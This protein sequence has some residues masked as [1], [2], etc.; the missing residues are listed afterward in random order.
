MTSL[1]HSLLITL[2]SLTILHIFLQ[3]LPP[4][5]HQAQ[6]S[7][8]NE[9]NGEVHLDVGQSEFVAEQELAAALLELRGHEI[10][11][12]V[13]VL[14]QALFGLLGIACVLVPPGIHDRDTVKSKC[15][16]S[17][18]IPLQDRV[19]FRVAEWWEEPVG[20]VVH[21]TQVS[22]RFCQ[23]HRSVAGFYLAWEHTLRCCRSRLQ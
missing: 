8:Q 23:V 7:S 20:L 18:V 17:S 12:V 10:Q 2:S 21:V 22:G 19:T 6:I 11:I 15:A 16:F 3:P 1:L 4:L 14:R 13:D 5:P 9:S